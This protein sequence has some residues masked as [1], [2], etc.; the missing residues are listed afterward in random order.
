MVL[1]GRVDS[2]ASEG[3]HQMIRD[4]WA[5]LVTSV[6]DV[7]DQLGDAGQTMQT[8]RAG[9]EQAG[10]GAATPEAE[11]GLNDV[12]QR[13]IAACDEPRSLD[14]IAAL[15]DLEVHAI[16]PELTMLEIRGALTRSSGLFTR[17][18]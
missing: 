9:R 7:L 14:Q 2:R 18:R 5:T 10:S 8:L 13:I 4:G 12:Q 1:P 16:T 11:P 3:S 6:S 17:R 15:T